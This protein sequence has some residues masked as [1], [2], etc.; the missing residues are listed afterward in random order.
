MSCRANTAAKAILTPSLLGAEIPGICCISQIPERLKPLGEVRGWP[1][2]PSAAAGWGDVPLNP[3]AVS[4]PSPWGSVPDFTQL[5]HAWIEP[6]WLLP[7]LHSCLNYSSNFFQSSY[8][9]P[10][11]SS[12]AW[13]LFSIQPW[14]IANTIINLLAESWETVLKEAKIIPPGP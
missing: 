2:A 9:R 7:L 8:Q 3:K 4:S 12:A 11:S 1:I 14:H 10:F 6:V 13:P 5:V